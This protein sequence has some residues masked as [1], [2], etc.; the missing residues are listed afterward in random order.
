[1]LPAFI[2]KRLRRF[3]SAEEGYISVEAV[4]VL[5]VMLWLFG[6]GWVYFDAF[7]QQSVNQKANYV[8]GDMI[9]RETDGVS[10]QY[11]S[12]TYNLLTMLTKSSGDYTDLR[13]AVVQYDEDSDTWSVVWSRQRGGTMS[14]RENRLTDADLADYADRLPPAMDNQQLVIVETWEDWAPTFNVGIGDFE[15]RTYSFTSPRYAP[16]IPFSNS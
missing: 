5:P 8:I 1:M 13:V 12:N 6:V 11:I 14:G 3:S 16:Q 7:R 4:I 9:S 2:Q 15:I 10:G